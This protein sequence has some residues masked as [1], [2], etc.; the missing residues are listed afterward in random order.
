MEM[1]KQTGILLTLVLGILLCIIVC[2]LIK[3]NLPDA[4]QTSGE[5]PQLVGIGGVLDPSDIIY[6][7][8]AFCEEKEW[9]LM[10]ARQIYPVWQPIE[11]CLNFYFQDGPSLNSQYWFMGPELIRKLNVMPDDETFR[12]SR[13][14]FE[15]NIVQLVDAVRDNIH[16]TMTGIGYIWNASEITDGKVLYTIYCSDKSWYIEDGSGSF[17]YGQSFGSE[18]FQYI[19]EHVNDPEFAPGHI[20]ERVRGKYEPWKTNIVEVF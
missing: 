8:G 4:V 9:T 12:C 15:E 16:I 13:A 19:L 14:K 17:L 1:K 18:S 11:R 5:Q 7:E 3:T 20:L 10:P 6:I 2:I